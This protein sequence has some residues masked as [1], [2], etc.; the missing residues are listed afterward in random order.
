MDSRQRSHLE[1]HLGIGSKKILG[2]EPDYYDDFYFFRNRVYTD[3]EKYFSGIHPINELKKILHVLLFDASKIQFDYADRRNKYPSPI[4]FFI[5]IPNDIRI[6][7]KGES[8]YFDLQSC[9]HETGH[10][11]HAISID[12]TIDTGIN[13]TFQWALQRY[14]Q[15]F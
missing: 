13:T 7:F 4:C 12:P 9:F 1:K 2:R 8:P 14:S 5:Q 6:L 11:I 3:F 10:A 15:F